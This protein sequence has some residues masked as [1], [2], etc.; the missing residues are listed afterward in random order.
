GRVARRHRHAVDPP[1]TERLDRER[2]GERRVDPSRDADDDLAEA[3]LVHV[4]A[5]AELEPDAHLLQLVEPRSD[6]RLHPLARPVRRAD[7]DDREVGKLAAVAS[8]RPAADVAKPA[9]DRGGR[10]DVDN[11][12]RLLEAGPAREQVTLL[13]EHERVSVEEQLV[14]AADGVAEGDE[15]RVVARAGGEHLL[16]LAVAKQVEG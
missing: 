13:V 16:A 4:V 7:V 9:P 6:D 3:V 14:L 10:L 8:E 2:G 5:Q 12:E 1:G 11:E 15:A